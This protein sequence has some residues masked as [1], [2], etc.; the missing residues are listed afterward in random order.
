[1]YEYRCTEYE[2]DRDPAFL[3]ILGLKL[4]ARVVLVL[5]IA[6]LVLDSILRYSGGSWDQSCQL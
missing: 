4:V 2:Y 3:K 5:S 1:E 6:V